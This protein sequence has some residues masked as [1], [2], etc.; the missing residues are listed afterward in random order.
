[1]ISRRHAPDVNVSNDG[2]KSPTGRGDKTIE[3]GQNKA[4]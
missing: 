4:V 2:G 1:M 3:T